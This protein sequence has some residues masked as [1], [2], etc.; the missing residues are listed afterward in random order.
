M[1]KGSTLLDARRCFGQAKL[2]AGPWEYVDIKV[3]RQSL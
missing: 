2:D 1:D 3:C